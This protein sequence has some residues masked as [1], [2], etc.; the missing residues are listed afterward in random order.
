MHHSRHALE[1]E[2]GIHFDNQFAKECFVTNNYHQC[3][4]YV[5][6]FCNKLKDEEKDIGRKILIVIKTEQ[7][8]W[9]F[10]RN[11]HVPRAILEELKNVCNNTDRQPYID[12]LES[13]TILDW[14]ASQISR[15]EEWKDEP[16]YRSKIFDKEI[17]PIIEKLFS[18]KINIP[19]F[20]PDK[21]HS[22]FTWGL[23]SMK[24]DE[25]KRKRPS[26]IDESVKK[27][28]KKST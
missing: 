17:F 27:S 10:R 7:F 13:I 22:L 18:E 24:K 23:T 11:F 6:C 26:D 16:Q 4:E 28:K 14:S 8:L 19:N 12:A 25:K 9:E 3:Y 2:T 5:A 21:L 20:S 15:L 1:M